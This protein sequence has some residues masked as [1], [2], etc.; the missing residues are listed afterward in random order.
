MAYRFARVFADNII[1]SSGNHALHRLVKYASS[2]G[3]AY[4]LSPDGTYYTCTG[5]GTSQ[6]PNI[7]IAD[8]V[9][10]ILVTGVGKD[11]FKNCR[12]LESVSIPDSVTTIGANAFEGCENITSV[13]ISDSVTEISSRAF[14]NCSNL[15]GVEIPVSVTSVGDW[16]FSGCTNLETVTFE[17]GA[18]LES[19]GSA[20]FRNCINL[21]NITLP[22]SISSIPHYA[23]YNC[24][25]LE[26][27]NIP[28]GVTNINNDAFGEC[29]NLKSIN[30][31]NS[32]TAI[33]DKV[34]SGCVSL[35]SLEIPENVT[36]I[37][38][39]VLFGCGSLKH[40]A[41]PFV[42]ASDMDVNT[43]HLGYM[44]GAPTYADN[45]TYVPDTLK[46]V[47]LT[48]TSMVG[49]QAFY[50]CANLTSIQLPDSLIRIEYQAFYGCTKLASLYIPDDVI[51]IGDEALVG[52]SSLTHITLPFIG[53]TITNSTH[54]GHM[55][56][57]SSYSNN[58]TYVPATLE[59]VVVT[60]GVGVVYRAF[61]KC[62]NIKSIILPDSVESIGL[63]AFES[64]SNLTHITLPFLGKTRTESVR[65]GYMFGNETTNT[66]V[67][68]TLEDIVITGGTS[69]GAEAFANAK[70]TTLSI[71]NSIIDVGQNAFQGCKASIYTEYDGAKYVGNHNNPYVALVDGNNTVRTSCNINH[72]TICIGYGAFK[73][74]KH[75][76][77]ITIPDSVRGIGAWAFYDCDGLP[78]INIPEGVTH[79]GQYAFESCSGVLSIEIPG[80]VK[81][82]S[83][84][85][86]ENCTDAESIIIHDGVTTI[87]TR[88]FDGCS[89]M[90][91]LTLPDSVKSI[92]ENAFASC[93][94]CENF[95]FGKF[96]TEI[97]VGAFIN[98]Q[99]ILLYD[100][101]AAVTVPALKS[102]TALAYNYLGKTEIRVP[103]GLYADWIS[104]TN[105]VDLRQ[106]V[107]FVP[108]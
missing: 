77:A 56:G 12:Q 46:S 49:P 41:V 43:S 68:T 63:G 98:N 11:A 74:Y 32:V 54:F 23:F 53:K 57:A 71:P 58:A 5:I 30:I 81:Y 90:K 107:T 1:T 48:N 104:S 52:C 65:L 103:A 93:G 15:T 60:G 79:I 29:S 108:V 9:N 64:C 24:L 102:S 95:V 40:L 80:T 10:G 35:T 89:K 59:S 28:Y 55:F 14:F 70:M 6:N 82:I 47:V 106:D 76:G 42:G 45:A 51:L 36:S 20:I 38:N 97:G 62:S 96:I 4:E 87:G 31:P 85:A 7:I 83:G 105:W 27:I 22:N 66:S 99:S 75:L 84:Y 13:A 44:F 18:K 101:S 88:A 86:F 78:S 92:G 69:I 94:S 21:K 25:G 73:S 37:G 3:L 100:F 34:F 17:N 72:N 91:S 26:T 8:S 50:E 39:R 33:G 19:I 67:T 61:Y 2:A 16:A